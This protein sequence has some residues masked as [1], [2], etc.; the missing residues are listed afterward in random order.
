M[1]R[2]NED[3]TDIARTGTFTAG[4]GQTVTLTGEDLDRIVKGFDER[5]R[6]VPLV[7]G[8]PKT[9]APAY[10]WVES[11]RRMGDVL[12]ARFKQVH[13]DVKTL[14]RNGHFKNISISLSADKASIRHIGL[15]GLLN[16]LFP[17]CVK[18]LFPTNPRILFLS[19][20][21]ERRLRW[22]RTA[23][24]SLKGN[25]WSR[26]RNLRNCAAKRPKKRGKSALS[27]CEER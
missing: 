8:H 24:Q 5:E 22:G 23:R 12:Q 11:F 13:E 20:L 9:S 27:V 25:L 21:W 15:L 26:G 3:W 1:E 6:R 2:K 10:G 17:V 18:C 14:V 16:R 4:N 19:S 7:F